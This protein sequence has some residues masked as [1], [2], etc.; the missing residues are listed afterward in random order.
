MSG[1]HPEN[2]YLGWFRSMEYG[3]TRTEIALID[4]RKLSS[5]P[6]ART[7]ALLS[8]AQIKLNLV[9]QLKRMK[10]CPD[11]AVLAPQWIP[12]YLVH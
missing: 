12:P 3:V 5:A 9:E 11:A 7:I 8:A 4:R 2:M 6:N 1:Q 10:T